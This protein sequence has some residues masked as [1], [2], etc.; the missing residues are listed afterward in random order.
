L[1]LAGKATPAGSAITTAAADS[2]VYTAAL[3]YVDAIASVRRRSV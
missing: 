2:P 1:P 3:V